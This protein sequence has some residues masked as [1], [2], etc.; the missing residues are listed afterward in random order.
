MRTA[1]G[2]NESRVAR[3]IRSLDFDVGFDDLHFCRRR[4]S[5]GDGYAR[6]HRE[7]YEIAPRHLTLQHIIII[8]FVRHFATSSLR[9]YLHYRRDWRCAPPPRPPRS[10]ITAISSQIKLIPVVGIP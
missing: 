9:V 5:S 8:L 10:M 4:R 6:G 3:A 2:M 1:R 7:T